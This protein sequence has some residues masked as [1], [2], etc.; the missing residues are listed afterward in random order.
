MAVKCELVAVGTEIL[1]GDIL[2]THA[3]F[4]SQELAALGIGVYYHTAVGDNEKRLEMSVKQAFSRSDLVIF[5][6]GLGPTTDDI[7]A[8]VVCDTLGLEMVFDQK[9]WDEITAF[10]A[11]KG[12]VPNENNRKQAFFPQGAKIFYNAHGTAPGF[13]VKAN[14]KTAVLLPGPPVELQAMVKEQV[15]PYLQQ[16]S[17]VC[18]R[19][20]TLMIYGIGESELEPMLADLVRQTDPTVALYA[21]EGQVQ[22]RV[23]G[24]VAKE[25][26]DCS[27]IERV[28]AEIQRRTG[29]CCYGRNISS[30]QEAVVPLLRQK[31]L[32]LAAA[33]SLTGGMIGKAITEV[34]GASEVFECGIISYS[35][36]IK[37]ELLGVSE[38]A[39]ARYGAVSAEVARQ[40]AKGALAVSGA[41]IAVAVTGFAGPGGGTEKDPVGT[42]Y[43]SAAMKG[44]TITRRLQLG[45]GRGNEREYI[46]TLTVMRALDVVR[47]IALDDPKL[48]DDP[49]GIDGEI[50]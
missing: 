41:D 20:E 37:H 18:F 33:E 38:A 1:L 44:K 2:N 25:H 6:G 23:T 4:L 19:S 50:V 48:V 11:R 17:G 13:A 43:L 46:R 29:L 47:R 26:P 39:L 31:G 34:P 49:D 5:S 35:D 15:I 8:K 9:A 14:G 21:K 30:L 24:A 7:T 36:R 27:K 16:E 42:V 40:M 3:Q 45:F 10:F 22:V 32:R 12:K 28:I